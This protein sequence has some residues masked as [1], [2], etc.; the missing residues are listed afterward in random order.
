[1]SFGEIVIAIVVASIV[2][3][4]IPTIFGL[5]IGLIGLIVSGVAKLFG[6]DIS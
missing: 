1:M 2:L 3:S 4:L 6:K 5:A